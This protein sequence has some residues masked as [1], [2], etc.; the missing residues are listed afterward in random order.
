L[1]ACTHSHKFRPSNLPAKAIQQLRLLFTEREKILKS[2]SSFER[3]SE[4]KDFMPKEIFNTIACV[5]RAVINQLKQALKRIEE[6][7]SAIIASEDKL[8]QQ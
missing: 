4:N 7:M 6:K 2:L 5:N 3:S 8:N 1:Y